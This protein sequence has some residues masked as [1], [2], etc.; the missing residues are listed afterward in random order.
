MVITNSFLV[1]NSVLVNIILFYFCLLSFSVTFLF[2]QFQIVNSQSRIIKSAIRLEEK[3]CVLFLLR[4]K[5]INYLIRPVIT[6][7]VRLSVNIRCFLCGCLAFLIND[8]Y[9]NNIYFQNFFGVFAENF[10]F[11]INF[12][13]ILVSKSIFLH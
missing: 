7:I 12:I 11:I 8:M 1:Q 10:N 2:Q 4:Y 5:C 6:V 3:L 9:R 13:L